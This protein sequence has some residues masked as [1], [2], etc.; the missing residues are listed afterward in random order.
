MGLFRAKNS[1]FKLAHILMAHNDKGDDVP[2]L[3]PLQRVSNL[4]LSTGI[5]KKWKM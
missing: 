2:H 3:C 1:D 5:L 4:I